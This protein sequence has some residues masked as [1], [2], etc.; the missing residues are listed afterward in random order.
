MIKSPDK[1]LLLQIALL[2][3]EY[4]MG[5]QI[6]YPVLPKIVANQTRFGK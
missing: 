3:R 6:S 2:F 5:T 4:N 1:S